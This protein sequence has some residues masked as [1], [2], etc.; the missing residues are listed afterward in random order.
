[1]IITTQVMLSTV[2]RGDIVDYTQ[3]RPSSKARIVVCPKCGRRGRLSL[4]VRNGERSGGGTITHKTQHCGW[5]WRPP[6]DVRGERPDPAEPDHCYF[7]QLPDELR[8][9]P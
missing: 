3:F 6:S 7:T 1:M 8:D 9:H 2:R 4:T 5:C